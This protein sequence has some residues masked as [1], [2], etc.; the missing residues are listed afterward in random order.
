MK[1]AII[2]ILCGI[3]FYPLY[4]RAQTIAEAGSLGLNIDAI[5]KEWN[6][7]H[8]S[9]G[10]IAIVKDGELVFTKGYGCADLEHSVRVT[11]STEFYMASISKQ[12]V[13]YCVA[14]LIQEGEADTER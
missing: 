12:F 8:S 7:P 6:N 13:G 11:P 4:S 2:F 3:C 10:A 14:R 9:G 1:R 5:F